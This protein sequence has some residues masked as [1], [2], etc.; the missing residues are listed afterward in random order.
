MRS[1]VAPFLLVVIGC[2]TGE[3]A[4]SSAPS[5]AEPTKDLASAPIPVPGAETTNDPAREAAGDPTGG[6]GSD[7]AP[8]NHPAPAPIP[9]PVL[10]DPGP[11]P[12]GTC[13]IT[14]DVDGFFVRSSGKGDYTAYV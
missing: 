7:P 2:S 4:T 13:T 10:P 3:E 9:T 11:K 8:A 6:A 1:V 14:K 12:A 5:S